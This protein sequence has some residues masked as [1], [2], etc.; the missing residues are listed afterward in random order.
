MDFISHGRAVP[1]S[2]NI[3]AESSSVVHEQIARLRFAMEMVDFNGKSVLD[4][5][6][7][8][9]YNCHYIK[10]YSMAEKVLGVDI[11]EATIN[12]AKSSFPDCEF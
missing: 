5:G 12:F 8:T 4:Y 11:S 2:T 1:T 7:G 9:G 3:D 6:C 10:R